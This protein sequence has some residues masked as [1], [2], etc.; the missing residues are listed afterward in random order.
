MIPVEVSDD[1]RDYIK[2]KTDTVTVK[3]E[4]CAS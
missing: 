3:L 4:A 2:E 1:A